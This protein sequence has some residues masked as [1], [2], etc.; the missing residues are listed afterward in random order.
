MSVVLLTVGALLALVGVTAALVTVVAARARRREAVFV[1][2]A[3]AA[4]VEQVRAQAAAERD[5]AVRAALEQ[6]AVLQ[7]EALGASLSAGR[8]ELTAKKDVI[9]ARLEQVRT[10]VRTEL[11]R[12]AGLVAQLGNV[13]HRSVGE[14]TAAL[15]AHAESTAA[16]ARTTQGLRE[17]LANSKTRGQ[18]GERM[19][20]DVLRLAGFV[21][22][23]N[24]R[25]QRGV[26]GGG[27]PDFT[28]PLPK[29]H[30]LYMD[31]KFP[32]TAYLRFLEAGTEAE[33]SAHREA[34]LRDVRIRVRELSSREYARNGKAPSVDYVLLFLPNETLGTFLFEQDPAL[35]DDALGQR[36]VLCTPMTL[37]ALLGVVR[38]AYDTFMVEQTSEEILRVLAGFETQWGKFVGALDLVGKR[39]ES[40]QKAFED[41]AGPRRRQLERPLQRLSALR[42]D[43]GITVAEDDADVLEL[44]A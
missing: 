1:P 31:V 7:R 13:T 9:D 18:W 39:L 30:E 17:A 29:G 15:S 32:L 6:A 33:R 41:L 20:E 36:V 28:F 44:G 19:A 3:V 16:L 24:Y 4:L 43:R 27:I 14:V 26:D 42:T 35:F 21:E 40:T 2:E 34:F 22:N 23:V 38:Q 37:F 5:A 11:D 8:E 10:E 12:V 25:K